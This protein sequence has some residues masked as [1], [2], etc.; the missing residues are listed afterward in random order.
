MSYNSFPGQYILKQKGLDRVPIIAKHNLLWTKHVSQTQ[1]QA[2]LEEVHRQ[3]ITA[4][5]Q[6]S[7][8]SQED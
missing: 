7:H 5:P 6:E 8:P 1:R 2:T 3:K 4:T